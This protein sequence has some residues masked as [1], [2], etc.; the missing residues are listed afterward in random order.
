MKRERNIQGRINL[1]CYDFSYSG[2]PFNI[3]GWHKASVAFK[4]YEGI[5][6]NIFLT[7]STN[8]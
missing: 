1:K 6:S 2:I 7:K 4:R 3:Q 8:Y 5:H